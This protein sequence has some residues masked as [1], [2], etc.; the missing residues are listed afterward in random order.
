MFLKSE[1]KQGT[2]DKNKIMRMLIA[3]DNSLFREGLEGQILKAAPDVSIF[4]ADTCQ[5]TMDTLADYPNIDMLLIDPTLS[6][7]DW[8]RCLSEV[9]K[10]SEFDKIVILSSF[11]HF[12][13]MQYAFT[14]GNVFGCLSKH[15]P[16]YMI[17]SALGLMLGGAPYRP[18][19]SGKLWPDGFESPA[20]KKLS[21][22]QKEVLRYLAQGLSNKQIAYH[23]S[24]AEATVKLHINALLRN[25]NVHNR[26]QAVIAA[27][28]YGI[29]NN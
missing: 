16:P 27:Q 1:T 23:M 29:L 6:G 9:F 8:R 14:L 3:D 21:P 26:T 2:G 25:F 17:A 15:S 11:R 5:D 7:A 19:V 10:H 24:L 4:K 12:D 20:V 18:S 22:R 28:R 13:D